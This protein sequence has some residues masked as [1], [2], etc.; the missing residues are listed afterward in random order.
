MNIILVKYWPSYDS[1]QSIH[2]NDKLDEVANSDRFWCERI[3]LCLS[4]Q[5]C[6]KAENNK[7]KRWWTQKTTRTAGTSVFFWSHDFFLAADQKSFTQIQIVHAVNHAWQITINDVILYRA[8][9]LLWIRILHY[10]FHHHHNSETYNE[11]RSTAST[12]LDDMNIL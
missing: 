11:E 6:C 5:W 3:H 1:L 12:S 10:T 9:E 2:L 4:I 8:S 7:C